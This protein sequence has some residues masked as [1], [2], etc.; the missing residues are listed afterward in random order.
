MR[1]TKK[2]TAEQSM[3]ALLA[4]QAA[5]YAELAANPVYRW[6]VSL[7][8]AGHLIVGLVLT[9][10][11]Q[12]GLV[13]AVVLDGG[14]GL[15][16]AP[17]GLRSIDEMT[18]VAAG[19]AAEKFSERVKPPGPAPRAGALERAVLDTVV[20]GVKADFAAGGTDDVEIARFCIAGVEHQPDE[21]IG[22]HSRI[23]FYAQLLVND[24][25]VRI[26]AAADTLFRTGLL[27]PRQSKKL[28][29]RQAGLPPERLLAT[30]PQT[31]I[32]AGFAGTTAGSPGKEL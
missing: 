5:A 22:R 21:W 24:H 3:A 28:L 25:A 26:V 14:G 9:P 31:T 23:R 6:R 29:R 19:R 15:A 32:P 7:H 12:R 4:E 30:T 13:A 18:M 27:T 10:P 11:R 16:Y 20:A 8:E 17:L 2:R 1:Q